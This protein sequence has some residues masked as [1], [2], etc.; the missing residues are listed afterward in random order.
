MPG[1]VSTVTNTLPDLES[2]L[3]RR[4]I[5]LKLWLDGNKITTVEAFNKFLGTNSLWTISQSL[6]DQVQELLKPQTNPEIVVVVPVPIVE[7]KHAAELV[8]AVESTEEILEQ[9]KDELIVP[10]AEETLQMVEEVSVISSQSN[11]E[12]KKS[13]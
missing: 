4:R 6:V 8:V 10:F 11:K 3:A 2:F 13:R 1:G 7:E 9:S 12:R 5:Q